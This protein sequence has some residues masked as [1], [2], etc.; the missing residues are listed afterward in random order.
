MGL[1]GA[2]LDSGPVAVPEW[3]DPGSCLTDRGDANRKSQ[4]R[5]SIWSTKKISSFGQ[6]TCLSL[7]WAN[8]RDV[9]VVPAERRGALSRWILGAMLCQHSCVGCGMRGMDLTGSK[10]RRKPE[11]SH[12][13]SGGYL[14]SPGTTWGRLAAPHRDRERGASHFESCLKGS[15]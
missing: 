10:R 12:D 5:R 9:P 13:P 3:K 8:R 14:G 11:G 1:K 4:T 15:Q 2:R 7:A 6:P